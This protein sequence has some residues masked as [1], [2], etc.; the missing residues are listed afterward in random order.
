MNKRNLMCRFLCNSEET[1]SHIFENCRPLKARISYPVNV[2]LNYI[3]GSM[4]NQIQVIK[5]LINIDNVRKLIIE[6]ICKYVN[7]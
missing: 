1:Q 6:D 2:Y 5:C 7:I 4:D 3:F